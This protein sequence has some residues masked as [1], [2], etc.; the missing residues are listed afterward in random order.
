FVSTVSS[1]KSCESKEVGAVFHTEEEPAEFDFG[2]E[3]RVDN[4]DPKIQGGF[5]HYGIKVTRPDGNVDFTG[6]GTVDG[7]TWL[8]VGFV[9][10]EGQV[11]NGNELNGQL[12]DQ[13]G[14]YLIEL[15]ILDMAQCS[16][17]ENPN[18]QPQ[19]TIQGQEYI[20]KPGES[21]WK[22]NKS[23]QPQPN[24]PVFPSRTIGAKK[25]IK[26]HYNLPN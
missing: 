19:I 3:V 8:Q 17:C 14:D 6:V 11:I 20:R 16:G 5:Y 9:P 1:G 26:L 2:F 21:A 7:D 12:T 18:E 13:Q 15:E 23:V 10:E 4:N 24:N 25:V 22:L